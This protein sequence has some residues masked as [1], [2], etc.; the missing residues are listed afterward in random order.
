MIVSNQNA[1]SARWHDVLRCQECGCLVY[2]YYK[3][4]EHIEANNSRFSANVQRLSRG[5][6]SLKLRRQRNLRNIRLSAAQIAVADYRGIV[7]DR[8]G[9]DDPNASS[10]GRSACES[11]F[12]TLGSPQPNSRQTGNRNDITPTIDCEPS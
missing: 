9:Q 7:V 12:G 8:L 4:R 3:E 11:R 5:D 6:A 10:K 1:G 2:C